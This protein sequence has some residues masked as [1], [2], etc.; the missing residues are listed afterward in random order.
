[1]N[2]P[3]TLVLAAA[4]VAVP[5]P[6]PLRIEISAHDGAGDRGEAILRTSRGSSCELTWTGRDGPVTCRIDLDE[7]VTE[8]TLIGSV[9][10]RGQVGR[11]GTMRWRIVDFASILRPL[12][13][14]TRP[15][16]AR[17]RAAIKEAQRFEQHYQE[18]F[19]LAVSPMT[20]AEPA[21][22]LEVVQAEERLAY[23]LP[24]EHHSLLTT[25]G[26]LAVGDSAFVAAADIK[27]TLGAMIEDWETPKARLERVLEP[28]SKALYSASTLLY[29][30]AGDGYGGLIYR[31]SGEAACGGNPAFYWIQQDGINRPRLLRTRDG[32]CKDYAAAIRWLIVQESLTLLEDSDPD[33]VVVDRSSPVAFRLLMSW[34]GSPFV[35][36][37]RPEWVD[38]E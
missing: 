23:A 38:I 8:I 30:S 10:R 5:H 28:Q 18:L 26:A 29:T 25:V 24:L 27:S 1:M 31:P 12:R 36:R 4:C 6:A 20:P 32:A 21:T 17:M 33:V 3:A 22:A 35:L 16:G 37:L 34:E 14:S 7:D 19:D 13:D 11:S 15:F 9:A 2:L